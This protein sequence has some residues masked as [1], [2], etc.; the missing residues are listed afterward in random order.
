MQDRKTIEPRVV[1][2]LV[3]VPQEEKQQVDLALNLGRFF[4][5]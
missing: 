2:L 4:L 1:Q 5:E 3:L